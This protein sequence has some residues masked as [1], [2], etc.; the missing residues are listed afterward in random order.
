MMMLAGHLMVIA[1][2][3]QP[4]HQYA[5]ACL[6]MQRAVKEQNK[7]MLQD[8]MERMDAIGIDRLDLNEITVSDSKCVSGRGML[9]LPEYAD[10]LLLNDFQLAQLDD[11]S[12]LRETSNDCTVSAINGCVD[13]NSTV[14]FVIESEGKMEAFMLGEDNANLEV[15]IEVVPDFNVGISE[16]ENGGMKWWQWLMSNAGETLITVINHSDKEINFVI[17]LN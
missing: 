13:A 1:N 9:Y 4:L 15:K 16:S 6:I 7:D 10:Y 5:E 14:K 17:G 11:V 12:L 2:E 8:A 3:A